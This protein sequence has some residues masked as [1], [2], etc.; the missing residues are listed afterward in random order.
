MFLLYIG[1]QHPHDLTLAV[2]TLWKWHSSRKKRIMFAILWSVLGLRSGAHD[3][4][5][6]F[7]VYTSV[8]YTFGKDGWGVLFS[9]VAYWLLAEAPNSYLF[10]ALE[11][12]GWF[13]W[14]E[15]G[16]R[17]FGAS[18][19]NVKRVL[20]TCLRSSRRGHTLDDY[21]VGEGLIQSTQKYP[22]VA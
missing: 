22:N 6:A 16:A 21:A 10:V 17:V 14:P 12:A 13:T 18:I 19:L 2:W 1:V 15:W 9:Y 7:G 5:N 20:L 3:K 11:N 4:V 8:W